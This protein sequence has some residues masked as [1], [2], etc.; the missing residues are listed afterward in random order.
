MATLTPE[1]KKIIRRRRALHLLKAFSEVTE[2]KQAKTL[3]LYNQAE[4]AF[5]EHT[6]A[7]SDLN[8]VMK[9]KALVG[10]KSAPI[11][12]EAVWNRAKEYKRTIINLYQV[13][14][15]EAPPSGTTSLKDRLAVCRKNDGLRN[16]RR[17]QP[18]RA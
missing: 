9:E 11:D 15:K 8:N 2:K 16:K 3:D 12:G 5:K 4:N 6:V 10:N 17:K 14:F 18:Q 7:D 13:L 1:Q